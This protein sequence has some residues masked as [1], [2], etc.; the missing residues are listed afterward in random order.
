MRRRKRGTRRSGGRRE[1]EAL[2]EQGTYPLN[3]TFRP[4]ERVRGGNSKR[5]ATGEEGT[6]Q[7]REKETER[8]DD[9]AGKEKPIMCIATAKRLPTY[10]LNAQPW[11]HGP[12]DPP[13]P[14]PA[15]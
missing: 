6:T 15:P 3:C 5:E 9:E 4:K 2:D 8:R 1:E 13:F 11:I 7:D 10:T 12:L 14:L